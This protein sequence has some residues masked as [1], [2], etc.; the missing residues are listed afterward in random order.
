MTV[1]ARER[2]FNMRMSDEEWSRIERLSAHYGLNAASVIRML[3][4]READSLSLLAKRMP[5]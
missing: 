3:L 4:K 5:R 1:R 2:L